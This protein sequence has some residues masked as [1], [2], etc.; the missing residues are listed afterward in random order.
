MIEYRE[1]I[2]KSVKAQGKYIKQS[3]TLG[4]YAV[5]WI[6]FSPCDCDGMI[7]E[8][9]IVNGAIPKEFFPAVEQGL[10]DSIKKGPVAG[11]PVTGLK[12]TLYDGSYH[13]VDSSEMSF[14]IAAYLAYKSAMADAEPVLIKTDSNSS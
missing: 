2:R 14:R 6:E 3:G 7:F 5:V 11:Y 8:E 10:R 1:T 9:R 13:P 4:Q 12:A